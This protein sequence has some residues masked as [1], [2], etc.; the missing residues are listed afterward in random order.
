MPNPA[1]LHKLTEQP[2]EEL[3]TML[4]YFLEEAKAG[5]MKGALVIGS[6]KNEQGAPCVW[7][8]NSSHMPMCDA[9][10]AI[11]YWKFRKLQVEIG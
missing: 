11:E 5:R 3:V 6:G 4:E 8:K 9:L 7:S 10:E 2:N 1:T